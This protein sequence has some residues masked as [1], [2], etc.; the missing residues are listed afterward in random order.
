MEFA[1]PWPY[2]QGEWLAFWSAAVTGA[3]GLLLVLFPQAGLLILAP[4]ARRNADARA[5]VRA[6]PGGLLAGQGLACILLAQQMLYFSLALSWA[7]AALGAFVSLLVPGAARR[8]PALVLLVAL[9]LALLSGIYV[10]GY[11]A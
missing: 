10:L 2:S 11:V 6:L 4:D 9:A 3:T 7:V 1:F 8:G 5:L